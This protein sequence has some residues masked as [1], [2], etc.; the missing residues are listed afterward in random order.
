MKKKSKNNKSSTCY[1]VYASSF[2]FE[3]LN[4]FNP[5]PQKNINWI[6][7]VS[8]LDDVSFKVKKKIENYDKMKYDAFYLHSKA[9]TN[10]NEKEA[11][12][13]FK[14]ICTTY[15]TVIKILQNI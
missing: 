11:D 12:D 7:G 15:T 9:E 5:Q 13:V 2:N 8:I 1:K 10:I 14:S 3:I 4:S 6:K